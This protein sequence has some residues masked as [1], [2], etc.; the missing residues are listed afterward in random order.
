M[1]NL[2]NGDGLTSIG[3]AISSHPGAGSWWLFYLAPPVPGSKPLRNAG[4]IGEARASE[5]HGR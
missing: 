2:V 1:L 3:A 4:A 5:S